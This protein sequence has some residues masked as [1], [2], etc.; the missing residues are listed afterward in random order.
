MVGISIEGTAGRVGRAVD[1]ISIEGTT[2]TVRI[3]GIVGNA[4]D[5]IAGNESVISGNTVFGISPV[6]LIIR[7]KEGSS[8]GAGKS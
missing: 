5:G 3:G 4:V 6:A 1:G 2:G 7:I 8:E